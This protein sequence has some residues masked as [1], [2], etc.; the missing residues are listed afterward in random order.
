[1]LIDRFFD[2]PEKFCE[3]YMRGLV[4]S[5]NNTAGEFF[6]QCRCVCVELVRVASSSI[7]RT[8]YVCVDDGP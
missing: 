2:A 6:F 4:A 5:Q 3:I 7:L 8:M 1:M